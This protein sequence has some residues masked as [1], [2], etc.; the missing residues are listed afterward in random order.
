MFD[1]TDRE[2]WTVV[3]GLVLGTIFLLLFAGG[4]AGLWSF[5]PGFLTA[6]A[7]RERMTRLTVGLWLMAATAWATVITGTWIVYPWYREALAVRG[8][9]D[10]AGCA[11]ATLPNATCSPRDFL[12]SEVSGDTATWHDFGMEWKE[13]IAWA[14]PFLATAV[15][16]IVAYY[17]PRLITRP[18]LRAAV[19]VML[20][21]AFA[22]A[23]IGGV[24]G[25]FLNKIAPIA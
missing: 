25:A 17:G 6:P 10:Y 15:A 22:A 12:K 18:W 2:F 4:I 14:A 5:R 16:F 3:H 8:N 7:I 20:V 21:G 13:H 9:D 19:I 11:G 24:F 1:V 23:A